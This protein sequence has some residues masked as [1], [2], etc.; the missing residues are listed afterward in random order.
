MAIETV[1]IFKN[2]SKI[3]DEVL[4]HRLGLVPL[5]TD[6]E[7]IVLASECDCEDND[8]PSCSVSTDFKGKRTK[9][10]VLWRFKFNP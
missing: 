5:E 7:S 4:A 2:D 1:S 9:S 8:C 10:R 3:F 6:I